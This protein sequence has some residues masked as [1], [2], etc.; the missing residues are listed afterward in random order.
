M[1]ERRTTKEI[2]QRIDPGYFAR[3]HPFR[4]ARRWA[5]LGASAAALLWIGSSAATGERRLYASG[6]VTPGHALIENDCARCHARAFHAVEKA[7]CLACHAAAPHVPEGKG[8][9]PSCASCHAE[10]RGRARLD[11]VEDS[12]CNLCHL[13]H[14]GVEDLAGHVPF[15]TEPRDQRLRFP[16]DLHLKADLAGGPVSCASCHSPDMAGE[17]FL[18][19]AF[20]AHCAQCH[21]LGFDVDFPDARVAHGLSAAELRR[22]LEAFYV[23]ALRP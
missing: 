20:E 14:R 7:S 1:A 5:T 12:H 4:R 19:V 8:R 16:H 23:G 21:P 9:D 10:H 15:R 2:A 3:P 22:H 17:R 13:D 6:P 18:P 11:A